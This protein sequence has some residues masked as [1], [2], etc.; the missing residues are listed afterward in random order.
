MSKWYDE[1]DKE[2]G[3]SIRCFVSN[4]N[5]NPLNSER[6]VVA[7][8][9]GRIGDEK[10]AI[11]TEIH[12]GNHY[13]FAI[14]CEDAVP[15]FFNEYINETPDAASRVYKEFLMSILSRNI[16]GIFH[17]QDLEKKYNTLIDKKGN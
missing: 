13:R 4:S 1:L 14:P 8:I 16:D 9:W 11:Y 3:K 6:L 5:E 12:S 7:N 10:D 17:V 2:S 15:Y